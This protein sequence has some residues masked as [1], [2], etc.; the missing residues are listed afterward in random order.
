MKKLLLGTAA[1]IALAAAQPVLAADASLPL[2][3]KTPVAIAAVTDWTGCYLGAQAGDGVTSDTFANS[4]ASGGSLVGGQ[5]GCNYQLGQIVL[6]IEAEAPASTLASRDVSTVLTP[7]VSSSDFTGRNRWSADVAARAGVVVNR[8]LIFGK[9]GVAAGR[10]SFS[11]SDTNGGFQNGSGTLNGL[12]LGI[13]FEYALAPNWSVKLEYDHFD[14]LGKTL[15]FD[16]NFTNNGPG[17]F[18]QSTSAQANVVKAGINY[19]FAGQDLAPVADRA[20][21]LPYKAPAFKAPVPAAYDWTGC[22]VGASAGAGMLTDSLTGANGVSGIGG[23]QMG[24]NVQTG[25]F[26]WGVEAEVVSGLRDSSNF[27]N[28][29]QSVESASRNRWSADVAARA[30]VAVD[31]ALIY[32]KAG[33]AAG[34]IDI[35]EDF[36]GGSQ[37]T[38]G[39]L[40]GAVFGAGI[41]YA[42][43]P[44][45]TVKLEYDYIGLLN[46]TL[47]FTTVG[48][49]PFDFTISATRNVV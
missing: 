29:I 6:G 13:G 10:F 34:R 37:D 43:A 33:V 35:A 18:D 41:E 42:L 19:R 9:A 25:S 24:C 49:G 28:A 44:H 14:Y 26:V 7:P 12:L 36:S 8:A 3:S 46:R 30:G 39:T 48:R 17:P 2:H 22:Y 40:T 45:W 16:A 47:P 20:R 23:G 11:E 32:G 1:I 38:S 5:L 31:R 27:A 21:S 4:F 15:H